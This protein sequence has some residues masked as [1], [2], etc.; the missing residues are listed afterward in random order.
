MEL[1]P[2]SQM[3]WIIWQ[4]WDG[5]AIQDLIN[6]TVEIR[7]DPE[8]RRLEVASKGL[9]DHMAS[10]PELENFLNDF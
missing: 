10:H 8:E 4:N 1:Y 7:R 6:S 3:P 9:E 2:K 5:Q